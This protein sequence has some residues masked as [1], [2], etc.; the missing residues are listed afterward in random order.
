MKDRGSKEDV[1]KPWILQLLRHGKATSHRYTCVHVQNLLSL[2][3][4]STAFIQFLF[5]HLSIQPFCIIQPLSFVA[6]HCCTV[7]DQHE[8]S[9][10]HVSLCFMFLFSVC[11]KFVPVLIFPRFQPLGILQRIDKSRFS[12]VENLSEHTRLNGYVMFL[13]P[14]TFSVFLIHSTVNGLKYHSSGTKPWLIGCRS[15]WRHATRNWAHDFLIT[16]LWG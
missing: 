14:F 12:A 9:F 4:S 2:P 6:L 11:M 1:V 5:P 15:I 10:I 7:S 8:I 16:L 3:Q 13:W